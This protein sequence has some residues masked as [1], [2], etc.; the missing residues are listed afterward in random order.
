MGEKKNK[1]LEA[2][3]D[4]LN[5]LL[6]GVFL[7]VEGLRFVFL[8]HFVDYAIHGISS[9]G[10]YL[11]ASGCYNGTSGQENR[12]LLCQAYQIQSHRFSCR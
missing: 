11:D 8:E 4:F 9:S 3:Y 10:S 5:N 2:Q 7:L 1:E 6:D 12:Y